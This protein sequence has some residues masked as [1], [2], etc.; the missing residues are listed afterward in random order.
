MVRIAYIATPRIES[1]R[2]SSSLKNLTESIPHPKSRS[3]QIPLFFS[4]LAK[5]FFTNLKYFKLDP[6]SSDNTLEMS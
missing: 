6:S 5:Y 1:T 4:I 3:L 2:Y